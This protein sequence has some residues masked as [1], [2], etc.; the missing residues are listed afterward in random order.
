MSNGLKISAADLGPPRPYSSLKHHLK[1]RR[2]DHA[3][4]HDGLQ[5]S[6]SVLT[7]IMSSALEPFTTSDFPVWRTNLNRLLDTTRSILSSPKAWTL[8]LDNHCSLLQCHLPVLDVL[9]KQMMRYVRCLLDLLDAK[10][11][12]AINALT[13]PEFF[14]VELGIL[15][16]T[17]WRSHIESTTHSSE[18]TA[19]R[20]VQGHAPEE[21]SRHTGLNSERTLKL[22]QEVIWSRKYGYSHSV[23]LLSTMLSMF[24]KLSSPRQA[25]ICS[26]Q[27]QMHSHSSD[28][29][30]NF[31]TRSN[32]SLVRFLRY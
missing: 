21:L 25:I 13:H 12:P 19:P 32:S 11:V 10:D 1:V 4:I 5:H 15:L 26:S 22:E 3:R 14:S 17:F 2:R 24:V 8:W 6:Q 30:C 23:I 18:L 20:Q 9:V 28:I 7:E 27:W 16:Q 29:S 31:Q